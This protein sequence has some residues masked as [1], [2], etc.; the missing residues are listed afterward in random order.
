MLATLVWSFLIYLV[1]QFV[2]SYIVVEYG[3]N[4][5]YDEVTPGTP[6]RVGIGALILAIVLTWTKTNVATMFTSEIAL[7]VLL[8]IVWVGI[9]ILLYRFQPWHGF[10]L[11]MA[12]LLIFAGL[13]TLVV[14]SLTAPK[15]AGRIDTNQPVQTIRRPSGGPTILNESELQPKK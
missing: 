8:A 5:L 3:Q 13:S 14:D 1:I 6:T 7:T 12:T 2:T 10:G 4:Y 11:A 15:P 9:Y